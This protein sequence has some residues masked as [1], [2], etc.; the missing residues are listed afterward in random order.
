VGPVAPIRFRA[1]R[2]VVPAVSER[3]VAAARRSALRL[4]AVE[5][6]KARSETEPATGREAPAVSL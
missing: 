3:R 4:V 2:P 6:L 1:G 5:E